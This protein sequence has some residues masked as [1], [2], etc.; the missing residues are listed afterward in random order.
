[1]CIKVQIA[2]VA[3]GGLELGRHPHR[4][5]TRTMWELWLVDV[6]ELNW[7]SHLWTR[8]EVLSAH[9]PV[10]S[11]STQPWH[12]L[13]QTQCPQAGDRCWPSLVIAERKLWGLP[14]STCCSWITSLLLCLC[15]CCFACPSR[16]LCLNSIPT[17][18]AR[19]KPAI[20]GYLSGCLHPLKHHS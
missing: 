1:M 2:L 20:W 15:P 14:T 18:R 3:G 11:E 5:H 4:E 19:V 13:M 10:S 17:P 16:E 7:S 8:T 12:C 9:T 6:L